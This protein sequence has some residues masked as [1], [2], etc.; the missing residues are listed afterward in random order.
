MERRG[1]RG[2]E[3]RGRGYREE[4]ER[5]REEGIEEKRR[6]RGKGGERGGKKA[7]VRVKERSILSL[8]FGRSQK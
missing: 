1:D 3:E 6:G 8:L 7:S 5:E 2:E 4:R